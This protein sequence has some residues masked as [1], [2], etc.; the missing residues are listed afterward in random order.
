MKKTIYIISIMFLILAYQ[1]CGENLQSIDSR[2]IDS[3]S[4]GSDA[5]VADTPPIPDPPT[6]PPGPT[7]TVAKYSYNADLTGAM[8]LKG[9]TLQRKQVHI[10]YSNSDLY[11]DINFY[12]C[13]L[14]G[15]DGS[16]LEPHQAVE[17]ITKSP[18]VLSVDMSLF[19]G[20]LRE[21]YVDAF[22]KDGTARDSITTTF[23][24]A[25][26]S[27][28]PPPPVTPGSAS[29][30]W[31]APT[32]NED[33]SALKD[34]AG[35][36]V[37]MSNKT[38]VTASNSTMTDVGLKNLHTVSKLAPGTYYFVVTAYNASGIESAPSNEGSKTIP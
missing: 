16:K 11:S 36:K 30:S 28:T 25:A 1:N 8:A 38:P 14:L 33:G 26:G 7:A 18:Y 20:G 37:Y 24:L 31:D 23:T 6:T 2:L 22:K 17:N 10:F 4:L 5:P 21:V 35:Y 32:L 3:G 34:L 27:V 9:A 29:L 13:A 12:C 19:N 15:A